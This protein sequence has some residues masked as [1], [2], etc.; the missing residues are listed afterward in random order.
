MEKIYEEY[1]EIVYKYLFCECNDQSLA[2]ELTQET[3]YIATKKIHEFRNECKLEVWLC[4]IAKHL[5]YKELKRIKKAKI[6][7]MDAE[8]GEI[9]SDIDLEADFIESE[10]KAE[11][12]R[13]IEKL[14]GP[15]KELMYLKLTTGLKFKD[16]A[17]IL[18]KTEVWT[19]VT[20]YRWKEEMVKKLKYKGE[21]R[22]E[23]K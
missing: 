7:S 11:V 2:E 8:I 9:P 20:F 15:S 10:E 17:E 19:R 6:V 18:G 12:F 16:V 3:F 13:E 14:K 23:A 1:S 21:P 4:Q 5:W 22:N